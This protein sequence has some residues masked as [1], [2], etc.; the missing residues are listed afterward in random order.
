MNAEPALTQVPATTNPGTVTQPDV[1]PGML[2]GG[3]IAA[4]Q[5]LRTTTI[6]P[7]TAVDTASEDPAMDTAAPVM[8]VQ[9]VVSPPPV[10]DTT[11]RVSAPVSTPEVST[12]TQCAVAANAGFR[13]RPGNAEQGLICHVCATAANWGTNFCIKCGSSL[14]SST[15]EK[16]LGEPDSSLSSTRRTMDAQPKSRIPPSPR[17]TPSPQKNSRGEAD[18]FSSGRAWMEDMQ[19][20]VAILNIQLKELQAEHDKLRHL[21]GSHTA[22]N[23]EVVHPQ[24]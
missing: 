5:H 8:D 24:T 20:Q 2:I 7:G 19:N 13:G 12:M 15:T 1:A 14:H 21:A 10:L 6:S 9:P 3:T 4:T 16:F 18:P 11:T 17:R 23:P 22:K